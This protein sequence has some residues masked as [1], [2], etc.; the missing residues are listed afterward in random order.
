MVTEQ[1]G[2]EGGGPGWVLSLGGSALAFMLKLNY[3]HV[4]LNI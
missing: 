1:L 2:W 4:L 3:L